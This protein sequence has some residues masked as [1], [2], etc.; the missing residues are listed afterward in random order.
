[1]W[2]LQPMLLGLGISESKDFKNSLQDKPVKILQN[3]FKLYLKS[4]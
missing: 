1:M 2:P 3:N 4:N